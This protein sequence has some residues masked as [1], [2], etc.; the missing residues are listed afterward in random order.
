MVL[1]VDQQ[2]LE[3]YRIS[4]FSCLN[5][6]RNAIPDFGL[7]RSARD[8]PSGGSVECAVFERFST[9]IP[10]TENISSTMILVPRPMGV[11]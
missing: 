8:V 1:R 2:R 4:A 11:V 7:V 9:V 6:R 3:I 5:L 10:R